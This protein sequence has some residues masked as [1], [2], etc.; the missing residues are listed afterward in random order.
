MLHSIRWRLVLSYVFLAFG[1]MALVGWFTLV[2]VERRLDSREEEVLIANAEAIARQAGYT[3]QATPRAEPL[4]Q[5]VQT[6]A[7]L[8]NVQVRIL[9]AE[10]RVIADSGSPGEI[11]ELTWIVSPPAATESEERLSAP[12]L[13]LNHHGM[14]SA[15][16]LEDP[17][18]T[19]RFATGMETWQIDPDAVAVDVIVVQRSPS[20]WGDR[21]EFET[22]VYR[23]SP[24]APAQG[25][26]GPPLEPAE[27]AGRVDSQ[28]QTARTSTVARSERV[29]T[30]PIVG[31][32]TILGQVELSQGPDFGAESLT[33]LRRSLLVAATTV[34]LLAAL[35]GL[36]MSRTLTGP[37]HALTQAAA[38]MR[39]GDLSA[40]AP[41]RSHDEIG[42]LA[43]QFNHMAATLEVSFAD[44]AA[45]RDALRRFIADASHELRTPITALRTFNDLLGGPAAA[46]P[47][48]QQEFLAESAAQIERLEW[49][50]AN[51]LDLSRL[52]GGLTPL[53]MET[54]AFAE[55]VDEV[56]APFRLLAQEKGIELRTTGLGA[57]TTIAAD[58][59][60]LS[61][62]LA[63]LL[64]NAIKF[65][66]AG[67]T[68]EVAMKREAERVI[69]AVTDSGP[70]INDG[71]AERIFERF[72]RSPSHGQPGSGLG[73]AIVRSVV[74]AHGGTVTA[75]NRPAGGAEFTLALPAAAAPDPAW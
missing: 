17:R 25:A 12:L 55:L 65:T 43:G 2:L 38:E 63:N 54:L 45:E 34:A 20:P 8:G 68:I 14:M 16:M 62:A 35:L 28:A 61:L 21:L 18:F 48:A 30:A 22:S 27:P 42:A 64:D 32:D 41:V 56:V 10:G 58:R 59:A 51:L 5:L 46:D 71:E 69:L 4:D 47:R 7:F 52:D 6:A 75:A 66:P 40:R 19:D 13:F 1:A 33:T 53:E 3:L 15:M 70:G 39:A 72:Y 74:H 36:V 37:L 11:G 23:Q 67:G 57:G 9:D 29:V 31:A 49:I 73:L 60:R 24:P 44:L 26:D 50:T